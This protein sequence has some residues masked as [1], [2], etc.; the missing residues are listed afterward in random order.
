MLIIVSVILLNACS[1]TNSFD[2][3]TSKEKFDR[4]MEQSAEFCI[5]K[6]YKGH[7]P[8]YRGCVIETASKKFNLINYRKLSS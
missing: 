7:E 1:S 3:L 2:D 6:G 8:E 4:V 5:K